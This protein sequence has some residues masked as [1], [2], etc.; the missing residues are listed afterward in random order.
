MKQWLVRFQQAHERGAKGVPNNSRFHRLKAGESLGD[1]A[2]LYYGDEN[3]WPILYAG[4]KLQIGDDPDT[5]RP[6]QTLWIP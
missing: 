3:K 1:V 5:L 2:L 4:N 6:G